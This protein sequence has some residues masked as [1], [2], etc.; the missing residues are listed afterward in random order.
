MLMGFLKLWFNVCTDGVVGI[1]RAVCKAL[2]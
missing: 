1:L 2:G